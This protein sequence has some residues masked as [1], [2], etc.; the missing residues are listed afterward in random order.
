MK[1][2]L[3]FS[4]L[5]QR[6]NFGF[7]YIGQLVSFIGTM[8]T[9]V[10]LPWQIYHL[11]H[12]TL[13]IGL[14]SLFRL[15]PLLVTALF[16]G[17]LADRYHRR[18]LLLVSESILIFGCL[19]LAWNAYRIHQSVFL[20]F[21]LA[22]TMS[23]VTGLH[24]P[25]LDSLTQQLVEKKD[26]KAV[27][28]L[29]SLKFNVCLIA[30]PALGGLLIA[31]FGLVFAYFFDFL[32]FA[33]SLITLLLMK[34]IPAPVKIDDASTITAL[35]QGVQYAVSHQELLGS[36][37]VDFVA[38]IF[39]MPN[40]LFPAIA[41]MYGGVKTLGLLYAA[42]AVG[43][44]I[45]SFFSGWASQVKRYGVAIAV[46]ATLW[47]IAMIGFGL[48]VKNLWVGLFFLT[49]A[50]IF[51]D[52]SGLFR[53]TLW[54]ES[55]PNH[56]RGRLAGIE[57]IS[58]LSG[59]RLGDIEASVVAELFGITASIVSGGILCVAAVAACCYYLPRFRQFK[60]L[61]EN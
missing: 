24:R 38:M 14:L 25:A 16:G 45:A 41:S 43:A 48:V 12:S 53:S 59:P 29:N 39:G 55:I 46:A 26:F 7:L 42:P 20:I 33:I 49:L 3:N 54:N 18:L 60:A 1:L 61:G 21:F 58:Y 11:T 35:R 5:W 13:M 17:V 31:Q 36:Y 34:Y 2:T 52:V 15:L 9:N 51:D 19:L 40:A 4:I 37:L 50:G 6:P 47:G 27:G 8:M 10:A 57:M 56:L 30:G 44:L 23:A 22:T 32:T 28:A